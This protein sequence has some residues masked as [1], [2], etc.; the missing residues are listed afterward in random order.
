[1]CI[2]KDTK[3]SIN[4]NRL[5]TCNWVQRWQLMTCPV[6]EGPSDPDVDAAAAYAVQQL[7]QQS[8]SLFPFQLKAVLSA[9]KTPMG[10]NGPGKE[11][12]IHHLQ[13]RVSQG[14]MPDQEYQVDVAEAPHGLVLKSSQLLL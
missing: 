3:G 10:S 4:E 1:M 6:Q 7:S 11:G 12:C 9:S 14:S 5:F 2:Y 8:N 13:L